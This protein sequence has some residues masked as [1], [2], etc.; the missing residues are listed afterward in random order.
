M[1]WTYVSYKT[2]LPVLSAFV[3]SISISCSHLCDDIFAVNCTRFSR[4]FSPDGYY[5]PNLGA[6]IHFVSSSRRQTLH[7]HRGTAQVV[8]A[9]SSSLRGSCFVRACIAHAMLVTTSSSPRIRTLHFL[10]RLLLMV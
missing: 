10:E 8:V 1:T 2:A 4:A 5:L 9:P 6:L 3:P 7:L